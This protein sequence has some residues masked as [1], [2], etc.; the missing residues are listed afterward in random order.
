[1]NI[2]IRKRPIA[3]GRRLSLFLDI[4]P[5]VRHPATGKAVRFYSL[6]LYLHAH[7]SSSDQRRENRKTLDLAEKVRSRI[8]MMISE[9]D[10]SFLAK[11]ACSTRLADYM[12]KLASGR[13]E[14]TRLVWK[15]AC[16]ALKRY[17]LGDR[18]LAS[19]DAAVLGGYREHLI[20]T[21]S[22]NTA[23]TYY[24]ML[25]AA[26]KQAYR[27]GLIKSNP[28]DKLRSIPKKN[29]QREYLLPDEVRALAE[30]PCAQPVVKNAFLFSVATGLRISD[31]MALTRDSIKVT[32]DGP[33]LQ[34][35]QKKSGKIQYHP[36]STTAYQLL[37]SSAQKNGP[38][39]PRLRFYVYGQ[40]YRTKQ[41]A[42]DDWFKNAGITRHITFHAARHT[43]AVLQL[44][45]GTRI[46][47]L[48]EL[49]G[50]SMLATTDIYTHIVDGARRAAA[51]RIQIPVVSD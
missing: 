29:T 43:Y 15:S 10:L 38:L 51:D 36:I 20:K 21:Y 11:E 40:K 42:F 30:T 45:A 41:A 37:A 18:A 50:H 2:K 49:L 34:Y 31:I 23:S 19:I 16:S 8:Y 32:D 25:S 47:V 13:K 48:R 28:V 44:Q 17:G 9:G 33:Y 27:E 26:L 4:T 22:H 6:S 5:P 12:S 35:R 3:K 7:P 46:E 1:M 14:G 39:F 24:S